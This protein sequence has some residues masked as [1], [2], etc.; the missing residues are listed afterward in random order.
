M[1]IAVFCASSNRIEPLYFEAARELGKEMNEKAWELVYGGTNCGL[2]WE[3]AKTILSKGGKVKGIIPGCIEERGVKARHLTELVIAPDMKERKQLMR[4]T[5]D[6]F[7]ALP[8]G[9]GTLEEITEVITLKQLG[10]HRKPIVFVNTGGFY[11]LFFSFISQA[12]RE[13]FISPAYAGLY[14][15]V[16][17]AK[18]A[19]DYIESYEGKEI[20]SKY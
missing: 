17:D 11:D 12:C 18:G 16:P 15:I 3:L 9:W 14:E 6:A 20:L 10:I 7:V 5:A 2:M 4:D 1:K 13:N 19:V 8:G